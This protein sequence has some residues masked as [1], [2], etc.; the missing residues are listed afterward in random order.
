M[1]YQAQKKY[2]L[3]LTQ[4]FLVGDDERDIIA[5]QLAGCKCRLTDPRYCTVLDAA[6]F[7]VNGC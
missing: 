5:G 4:C 2:S 3:D 1:L 6:A 7:I